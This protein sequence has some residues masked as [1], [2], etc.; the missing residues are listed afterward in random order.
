MIEVLYYKDSKTFYAKSLAGGDGTHNTPTEAIDRAKEIIDNLL[1]DTPSNYKE[2]AE[3]LTAKLTWTGY[4]DCYLDEKVCE[5]IV[6]NFIK[7]YK[8]KV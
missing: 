4:E 3:A 6:G 5:I 7:A 1:K 2:L 8:N